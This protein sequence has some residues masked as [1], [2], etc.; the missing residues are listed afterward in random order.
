MRMKCSDE[1]FVFKFPQIDTAVKRRPRFWQLIA[2]VILLSSIGCGKSEQPQA[3]PPEVEVVQVE[4]KDV[5]IWNEWVGTLDGLVNAQIKPQV[6]GYLLRQTYKEGSFVRKGQLLFEI[7]P[8]TFQAAL[9]QT[10]AQL[11]NANGQL[12]QAEAN[13]VKA[14]LDVNRYTPLAKEQAVTQQD[15]DNAIQANVAAQA[16]VRAAKAQSDAAK[17]QVD[18][19]QLNL[20]FT[21][22]V[23]QIDGIAGIAQAQIGDLV[24]PT[25]LLTTVSTLDPIKVYFP[26]SEKGYLNYIKEN[27]DAAKR[28]EQ[29]RQLG[30]EMILADGSRYPHE[31]SFSFADRQVDVK[32]GTLRLQGLF[33]NPGNILRPGQFARVRAITTTKKGALLVPQR[34]VTELQ[35]GYQVAVVGKDNKVSIR[36]VKVG[37]RVGSL[38]IVHEGLKPGERVVAEGIQ[39]VHADMTVNPKP[40]KAMPEA[41]SAPT[42]K[43]EPR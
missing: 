6:T 9:D 16:Q 42:A 12:A 35:G 10:R 24:G 31:G 28:A 13:Q 32:T 4:Q 1:W 33:P 30:L 2:I 34:A 15:L 29:E 11:A 40:L 17:A 7:D 27:P 3:R 14:Q 5:P 39:R 41:K 25:T 22:I 20:G 23:S 19:A 43:S 37:E 36:P 26:V 8:R 38:W 21:R 18:A